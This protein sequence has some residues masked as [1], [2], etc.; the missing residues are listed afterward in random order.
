MKKKKNYAKIVDASNVNL[1]T[2]IEHMNYNVFRK[3]FCLQNSIRSVRHHSIADTVR[4][5]DPKI[6]ISIEIE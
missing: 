3:D 4:V 5:S 1:F 2:F 6:V